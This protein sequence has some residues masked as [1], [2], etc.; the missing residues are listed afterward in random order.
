MSMRTLANIETAA[1]IEYGVKQSGR[2][3]EIT[4]RKLVEVYEARGIRFMP[5]LAG[6]GAGVRYLP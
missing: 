5:A 3:E 6:S 4:I 1:E 2:F